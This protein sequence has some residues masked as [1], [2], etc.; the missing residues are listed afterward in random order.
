MGK[1]SEE[2]IIKLM[3]SIMDVSRRCHKNPWVAISSKLLAIGFADQGNW[4]HRQIEDGR[5]QLE[6]RSPLENKVE[7]KGGWEGSLHNNV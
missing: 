4:H 7:P 6:I 3:R 5:C 1:R 2:K